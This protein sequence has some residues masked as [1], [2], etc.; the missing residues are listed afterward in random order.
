MTVSNHIDLLGC[1]VVVAEQVFPG[2]GISVA[3][4]VSK[5]YADAV[6]NEC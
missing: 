3:N 6:K 4:T 5:S 1:I 2:E